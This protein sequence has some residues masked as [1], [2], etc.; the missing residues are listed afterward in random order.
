MDRACR[1]AIIEN[2][3]LIFIKVSFLRVKYAAFLKRSLS[4]ILI[5]SFSCLVDK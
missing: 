1:K 3:N 4:V 2:N 5:E